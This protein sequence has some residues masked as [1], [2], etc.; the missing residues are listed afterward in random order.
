MELRLS[1]DVIASVP[2]AIDPVVHMLWTIGLVP[3]L[4]GVGHIIGGLSIRS[5]AIRSGK[6]TPQT[7]AELPSVEGAPLNIDSTEPLRFDPEVTVTNIRQVPDSV[8]DR[9]TNILDR[10]PAV[11]TQAK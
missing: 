9:T 6:I 5:Q 8:T 10:A 7:A 3:M 1:P 4:S 2:F 11:E